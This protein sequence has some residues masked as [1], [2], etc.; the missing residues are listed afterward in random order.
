MK[1]LT[2]LI[3]V[4]TVFIGCVAEQ[5]PTEPALAPHTPAFAVRTSIPD[6]NAGPPFYSSIQQA[7]GPESL[8]IP[9]TAELAAVAFVR[10]PSCVPPSFNL[11]DLEDFTPAFPG[12][13]PRFVLC[14]LTVEG[15][16]IWE[17]GPPPIDNAPTFSQ[18][19][20][21]GAVPVWFAAW[22]EVEAAVAD[23]V[24][25]LPELEALPSLRI[26]SAYFYKETSQPGTRKGSGQGKIEINAHGTLA[27]GTPF[28][29]QVREM[30]LKDGTSVQR[31]TSIV[32][33]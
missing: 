7:G 9:H 27:N 19:R 1:R 12:G 17:N 30:G 2:Q 26:G 23:G 29:V 16:A 4:N 21:L 22:P 11:L 14:G 20:G 33:K 32:L 10:D 28:I 18:L 8:F 31:H 13:P 5:Q 3:I 25:T 6:E 15:F 24:L